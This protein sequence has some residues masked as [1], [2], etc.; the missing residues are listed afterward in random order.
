MPEKSE[1]EKKF[2]KFRARAKLCVNNY[3]IIKNDLFSLKRSVAFLRVLSR[4]LKGK[5]KRGKGKKEKTI[6][7]C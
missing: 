2:H 7:I 5:G 6:F 3:E 1:H 4:E